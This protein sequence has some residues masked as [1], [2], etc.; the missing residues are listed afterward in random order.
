LPERRLTSLA[1]LLA[2]AALLPAIGCHST[3]SDTYRQAQVIV[4]GVDGLDPGFV[5]RHWDDLPNL[6]A[7]RQR[8][9]F[10]RLQT[11]DPPQ[12]P[13]AW[14]SFITGLDP[15]QHGIFDFVQRNPTTLQP[16]SSMSETEP[17]RFQ[18]SL[19]PYRLPLSSSRVV[20]LRRGTA[21]WQPLA[22]HGIPVTI[23]RMPTNYPPIA[24]GQALSGMGT[25]D[26]RGTLGS[27]SYYTDDPDDPPRTV[28]GGQVLRTELVD[29]RARLVVEGAPNSLHKDRHFSTEDLVVDVDPDQPVARL[30]LG[31]QLAVLR[32]NE[33]SDWLVAD[34]PLIPHLVSVRGEFR[35]FVKQ[36]H[37]HLGIYVSP[38]NIDPVSPSLPIS[39]PASFSRTVAGELGRFYTQGTPEDTAALRQGVFSLPE[40]L[41]QTRLVLD[42]E[43][44]LLR[45]SLDHFHGGLLFFYFS[46]IDQNSHM[47]WGKHDAELL[48]FYRAVDAS[49]GEV[50]NRAPSA[51]IIVLSDHG[52]TTFDRA[53]HLN[54]WLYERGFLALKTRPGDDTT[55]DD[56]DWPHT[57]AYAL[58]LNGLYLNLAGREKF[59]SLQPGAASR[60]VL[61]S[62][63]EQLLAFR[64]PLNDR[65]VVAAVHTTH[66]TAANAQVAPDLI[67][68]Y[69]P[70]YRGSWQTGL[71]GIPRSLIEDNTDAWIAD[72]CM[73]AADIPGVLF[74]SRKA[75][76]P[77]PKLQDVTAMIL[78]LFG[79]APLY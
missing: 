53:V 22:A 59:G 12:S 3:E 65:P 20:S 54:T 49:I 52:F 24:A 42:D 63:R 18:L 9:S 31:D 6:A 51:G 8:G 73:N 58:G 69:S 66:P 75:P 11:T 57:T 56:V 68:G 25:P 48:E 79:A 10:Q 36:L 34:F 70:G 74:T 62:L 2:A 77:H 33:W 35:V 17:P 41:S 72:H 19:G 13:V 45:Y 78:R 38:V 37:P 16:Y 1:R 28:P 61:D 15:D 27:F 50:A 5:E 30:A 23:V 55:L 64:D 21:F 60:A 43:R 71:G 44:R 76:P 46:S 26:L 4:L 67:V 29:H 7:L 40:F 14:S 39:A 47:L 32:E